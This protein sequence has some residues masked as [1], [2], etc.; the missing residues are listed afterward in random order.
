MKIPLPPGLIN[1]CREMRHN[2]TDVEML[3][4]RSLRNKQFFGVRFRR[5][6][7]VG[8]YILDFYCHEARLAIELDGGEHAAPEQ[9]LY[10]KERTR[11][12]AEQE[13]HVLRF[14]N[15]EVIANKEG[16]LERI[17]LSLTPTLS[18][19]ERERK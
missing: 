7:P 14:W 2:M 12:L 1:R 4:W 10:D 9:V 16:I 6:H 15:N 11:Y 19:G 5:Q 8:P 18:R 13:I 17:R 3:L